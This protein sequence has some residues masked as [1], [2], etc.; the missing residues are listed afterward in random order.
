MHAHSH[1]LSQ[2][3]K[4]LKVVFLCIPNGLRDAV[5]HPASRSLM[6][7]HT[8]SHMFSRSPSSSLTD[9]S[10]IT[11]AFPDQPRGLRSQMRAEKGSRM[12]E[13]DQGRSTRHVTRLAFESRFS[14]SGRMTVRERLRVTHSA[15]HAVCEA[16]RR[17]RRRGTRGGIQSRWSD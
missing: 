7:S 15:K 9:A 10:G 3:K 11:F 14:V 6:H 1:S 5:L 13:Q 17:S 8:D 4:C 12:Q 2:W 16:T